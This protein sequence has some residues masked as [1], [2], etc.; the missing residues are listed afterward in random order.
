MREKS[1]L[2][3][4]AYHEAGHTLVAYFT[5]DAQPIHK[6]NNWGSKLLKGIVFKL[7]KFI[8]FLKISQESEMQILFQNCLLEKF[9]IFAHSNICTLIK[10]I[11]QNDLPKRLENRFR[12]P[13]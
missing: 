10:D 11:D 9:A 12:F 6:V 3:I 1:D 8:D 5:E 13:F 4:T 2:E 7:L